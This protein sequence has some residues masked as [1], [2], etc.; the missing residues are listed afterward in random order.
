M[1]FERDHRLANLSKTMP[2]GAAPLKE[3]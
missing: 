1:V 2:A 3:G